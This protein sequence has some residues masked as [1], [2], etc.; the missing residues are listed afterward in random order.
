MKNQKEA[1]CKRAGKKLYDELADKV[2]LTGVGI[3][4]DEDKDLAIYIMVYR[5]ADLPKVPKTYGGFNVVT[6]VT[7]TIRAQ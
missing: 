7:G 6:R 2:R 3:T 4:W 5:K 1:A